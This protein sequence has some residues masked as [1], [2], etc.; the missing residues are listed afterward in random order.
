MAQVSEEFEPATAAP[1]PVTGTPLGLFAL[2]ITLFVLSTI[3]AGLLGDSGFAIIIGLAFFLGGIVILIAGL[4]DFRAGNTFTG[5]V[6]TSYSALWLSFGFILLPGT[7]VFAMMIKENMVGPALGTYL[8]AWTIYT[9]LLLI[10]VYRTN[11][12]LLTLVVLLV[13]TLGSLAIHFLSGETGTTFAVIGGYLGIITSA[14]SA[15]L[16][17]AGLMPHIN[18][19]VS[20]PVGPLS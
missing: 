14:V 9:A 20:L 4:V 8:L 5:T 13:L 2:A 3:N 11:V 17:L 19:R 15:Y 7:T 6:F 10:C 1:A 16:G 12:V 18:P